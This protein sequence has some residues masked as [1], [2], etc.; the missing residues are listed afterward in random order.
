ME[1]KKELTLD[2]SVIKALEIFEARQAENDAKKSADAEALENAAKAQAYDELLKEQ[3]K[4]ETWAES[5]KGV[6][7]KKETKSGFSDEDVVMFDQ[8]LRGK[9]GLNVARKALTLSEV[10]YDPKDPLKSVRAKALQEDSATEGGVLVPSDWH[11]SMIELRDQASF[12]RKMGV[13]QITT[14]RDN[15]D[16][17]AEATSF[18]KFARTAEEAAYGTNDPAL[19]QNNVIPQKWTKLTKISEELI[20]DDAFDLLGFMQRGYARAMAAT[21]NYYCSIGSGSS[22]H[23]GI[24]E[25]GDTDA[26]TFDSSANITAD[27]IWELLYILGSGYR[28][29]AAWLMASK[30]FSYVIRMR[31]ANNWAFPQSGENSM[32]H[33]GSAQPDGMLCGKP[34]FLEDNCP[35]YTTG[36]CPIMV[37]D[38]FYYALVDRSGLSIAR[39]DELYKANG[40]VG[41][42]ANFRQSGTVLYELAFVGG[43]MA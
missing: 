6:H 32:A 4:D 2:E 10:S 34:V 8:Y 15:I 24:M 11:S 13:Q 17:P 33:A 7:V 18:T 25:G 43:A 28:G 39:L 23:L 9:V 3:E 1:E 12:P 22:Q 37:G 27:E 38:P 20:A 14:T 36:L 40:Q 26:L 42:A 21:E 35:D 30:T 41:F 16:I 5:K 31:D 19:A 29:Q